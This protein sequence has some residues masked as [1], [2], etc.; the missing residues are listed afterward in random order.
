MARKPSIYK[1]HQSFSTINSKNDCKNQKFVYFQET[2][3]ENLNKETLK[4]IWDDHDIE[5]TFPITTTQVVF[6]QYG[7][8]IS[9]P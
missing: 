7:R 6:F 8:I 4:S 3:A 2:K 1:P 9:S 5:W